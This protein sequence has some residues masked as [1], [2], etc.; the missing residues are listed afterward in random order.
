[1][2]GA[3]ALGDEVIGA[4]VIGTQVIGSKVLG[5]VLAMCVAV[6]RGPVAGPGEGLLPDQDPRDQVGAEGGPLGPRGRDRLRPVQ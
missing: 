2:I 5:G 4:E 1:M 6:L 3:Q